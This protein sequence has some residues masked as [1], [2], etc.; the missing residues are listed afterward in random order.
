MP[1]W[2]F[3]INEAIKDHQTSTHS[4]RAALC[5]SAGWDAGSAVAVQSPQGLCAGPSA[6][7]MQMFV[8]LPTSALAFPD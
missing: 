5:V 3:L 6:G 8:Q 2:L 7:A 4:T 1:F